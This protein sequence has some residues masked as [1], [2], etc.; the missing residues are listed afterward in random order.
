[1]PRFYWR[2]YPILWRRR[3]LIWIDVDMIQNKFVWN[4]VYRRW[5]HFL[6]DDFYSL[7]A[8]KL[9]RLFAGP[10][11]HAERVL[12]SKKT[13]VLQQF[14]R[15]PQY[16]AEYSWRSIICDRWNFSVGSHHYFVSPI[17]VSGVADHKMPLS[18]AHCEADSFL[19]APRISLVSIIL[20]RK[21]Q[22]Y[23]PSK[24]VAQPNLIWTGCFF[25]T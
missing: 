9:P 24:K 10:S 11:R 12:A 5:H 16:H 17:Y 25:G 15:T 19:G 3:V 8:R 2:V 7:R 4:V 6:K 13:S 14:L 21:G 22:R 23:R 18:S 1:M 20:C